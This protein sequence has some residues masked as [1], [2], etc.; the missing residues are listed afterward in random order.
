[1]KKPEILL[2]AVF[3][4]AFS[5]TCAWAA[6][7]TLQTL[8]TFNGANGSNP[9]DN[10]LIDS[11]GNIYGTTQLGGANS[12]GTVFEIPATTHTLNTLVTFTAASAGNPTAGLISDASGNLYGTTSASGNN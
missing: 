7:P 6:N 3:A 8:A 1:M 12:V 5:C 9:Q 11:A 2:A 10:V 4:T